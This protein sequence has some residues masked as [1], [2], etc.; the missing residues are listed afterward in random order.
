[1]ARVILSHREAFDLQTRL[2]VGAAPK[3]SLY[4]NDMAFSPFGFDAHQWEPVR[5]VKARSG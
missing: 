5:E 3:S 4:D 2:I 1:L